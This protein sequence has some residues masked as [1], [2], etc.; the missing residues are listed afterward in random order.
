MSYTIRSNGKTNHIEGLQE[1]TTGARTDANVT[2]VVSYYAQSPCASLTRSGSRMAVGQSFETAKE[3]LSAAEASAAAT[4]RKVCKN[5]AKAAK[6]A[7]SYEFDAE[8]AEFK[9]EKKRVNAEL[10]A[11]SEARKDID[12]VAAP[13]PLGRKLAKDHG[14]N[15]F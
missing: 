2:G 3:A 15:F 11:R 12:H 5:C 10:V 8:S 4:G 14:L 13:H 6:W 7:I 1:V 9:A